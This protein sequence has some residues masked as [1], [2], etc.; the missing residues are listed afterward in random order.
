MKMGPK[1]KV[2]SR[3]T[4]LI[5]LYLGLAD[6]L[7]LINPPKRTFYCKSSELCLALHA[8]MFSKIK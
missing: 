8:V 2:L 5:Y 1:D 6:I 4:F 3:I 7:K